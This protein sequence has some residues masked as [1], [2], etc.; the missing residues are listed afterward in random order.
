MKRNNKTEIR[1]PSKFIIVTR[2]GE[3]VREE[4]TKTGQ[5]T[6]VNRGLTITG[7]LEI[8]PRTG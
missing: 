3:D 6:N 8:K 7:G 5:K 4:F 1:F 2:I